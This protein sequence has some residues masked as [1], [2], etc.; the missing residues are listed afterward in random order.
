M[1]LILI[2]SSFQTIAQVCRYAGF[3][4]LYII[5]IAL[6]FESITQKK[7][8]MLCKLNLK[9]DQILWTFF[10][11]GKKKRKKKVVFCV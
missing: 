7:I 1:I 6:L 9:N 5:F 2:V 8:K 10:F 11:F 3:S 4:L